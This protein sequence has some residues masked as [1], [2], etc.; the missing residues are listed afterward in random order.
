[1]FVLR[2]GTTLD[3]IAGIRR[4]PV[5]NIVPKSSHVAVSG[6]WNKDLPSYPQQTSVLSVIPTNT[7][8]MGKPQVGFKDKVN[9]DVNI[10]FEP[11]INYKPHSRKPLAIFLEEDEEG[12]W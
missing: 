12:V 11:R 9:N 5:A 4:N 3:E 10:P 7:K 8:S 2:Q 1:M 6:S